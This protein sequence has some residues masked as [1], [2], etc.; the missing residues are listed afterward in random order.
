MDCVGNGHNKVRLMVIICLILWIELSLISYNWRSDKGGKNDTVHEKSTRQRSKDALIRHS[1]NTCT[2]YMA[3]SSVHGITSMGIYTTK[4]LK[5]REVIVKAIDGLSIPVIDFTSPTVNEPDSVQLARWAWVDQFGEYW[6]G[7]GVADQLKLEGDT[8]TDFKITFSELPN[9]HCILESLTIQN[10]SHRAY[11]DGILKNRSNDPGIGAFSYHMGRKILVK[12]DV[13]AGEELF[14]NYGHCGPVSG[15]SPDWSRGIARYK[16]FDL[17]AKVATNTWKKLLKYGRLDNREEDVR[18]E[19]LALLGMYICFPTTKQHARSEQAST[20]FLFSLCKDNVVY[21]ASKEVESFNEKASALLPKDYTT[22]K[23]IMMDATNSSWSSA[24]R[25]AFRLARDVGTTPRTVEWIRENGMCVDTIAPRPSRILEHAGQ[26][27]IAKRFVPKGEIIVPAPMLHIMD[28]EVLRMNVNVEDPSIK[29]YQ[30]LMNYCFGHNQSSVLLCPITNAM[31]INHC[32]FHRKEE[33]GGRGPNAEYRWASGWDNNRTNEFL[34]MSLEDLEEKKERGVSIEVYATRDIEEGE[35]IFMDYG[36]GWEQAWDDHIAN[37]KPPSSDKVFDS[38][39]SPTDLND[40]EGP[41][42]LLVSHDLRKIEDHTNLFTGCLFWPTPFDDDEN[43]WLW[44]DGE[45]GSLPWEEMS[46]ER[47]LRRFATGDGELY[48]GDYE[49]SYDGAY[50]PC[51]VI[52][53]GEY[54][55][56]YTVRILQSSFRP[57][58]Q[59]YV[60]GLPRFVT[61]FPRHSIRYFNKPYTSDQHLF[62]AFRHPVEFRDDLFPEHWRNLK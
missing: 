53:V 40:R 11:N 58:T 54:K 15:S 1:S 26:G 21:N 16:D 51:S 41:L 36:R 61:N 19:E 38:Y 46:D 39:I 28:K 4:N 2:V 42:D 57:E 29:P 13:R 32:S 7:R 17:A 18:E 9:H 45:N 50:W 35:E 8:A 3:P 43:V 47:I 12:R 56:S 62:R 33:C 37:W 55:D 44:E 27:A 20:F 14:L 48:F 59:W 49:D 25:V 52:G 6:W 30:L 34:D 23:H 31:L 24:N 22:L 10:P 60:Q 5:K